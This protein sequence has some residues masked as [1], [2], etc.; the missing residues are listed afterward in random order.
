MTADQ[1][2][3]RRTLR[4]TTDATREAQRSAAPEN[5]PGHGLKG[6]A[7]VPGPGDIAPDRRPSG[8][9]VEE[10]SDPVTAFGYPAEE[11]GQELAFD[12]AAVIEDTVEA[13]GSEPRDRSRVWPTLG[14]MIALGAFGGVVW[15]AYTWDEGAVE[16][17]ELPV[18]RAEPGPIKSR[19]EDPG[20]LEV[21]YQDQLVLNEPTPD[22]DRP[23]IERLLPPPETPLPP[24]ALTA[25][26][27]PPVESAAEPEVVTTDAGPADG[28]IESEANSAPVTPGAESGK[29]AADESIAEAEPVPAAPAPQPEP[30]SAAE[31]PAAPA[32]AAPSPPTESQTAARTPESAPPASAP[33]GSDSGDFV[34]QLASLKQRAAVEVEWARLQKA[35]PDLLGTKRLRVEQVELGSRGTFYRVQAGFFTERGG[36]EALCAQLKARQQDC[37]VSRR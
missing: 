18:V 27:P 21:P 6:W 26:P 12:E 24:A 16:V 7:A 25:P 22:P 23:Q 30:A 28:S 8:G 10:T 3:E 9:A 32:A 2:P 29:A 37:L 1:Q 33:A 35:Y 36:A 4:V 15:Y 14:V 5:E 34:V 31:A 13:H 11:A 20:G 19:P 17:A